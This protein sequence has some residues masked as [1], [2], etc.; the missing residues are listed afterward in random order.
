MR[1]EAFVLEP[2]EIA[3]RGTLVPAGY[4]IMPGAEGRTVRQVREW[5][6]HPDFPKLSAA[7]RA[8]WDW[9][10][11]RESDGHGVPSKDGTA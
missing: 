5:A 1:A 9:Y 3:K 4:N 11:S 6:D 8:A 2:F 7:A 10:V